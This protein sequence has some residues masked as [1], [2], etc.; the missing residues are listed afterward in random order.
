MAVLLCAAC[1]DMVVVKHSLA[2]AAANTGVGHPESSLMLNASQKVPSSRRAHSGYVHM[3]V[4]LA[5]HAGSALH[6]RLKSAT[7]SRSQCFRGGRFKLDPLSLVALSD[8]V[9]KHAEF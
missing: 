8:K 9:V 1:A 7:L 2:N 5:W 3:V 4:L 6:A